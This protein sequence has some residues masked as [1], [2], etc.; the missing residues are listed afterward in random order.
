MTTDQMYFFKKMHTL[1][2]TYRVEEV[3]EKIRSKK[4]EK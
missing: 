4:K 3:A 1:L 2:E